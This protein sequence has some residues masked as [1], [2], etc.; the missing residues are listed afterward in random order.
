MTSDRRHSK[1]P[2]KAVRDVNMPESVWRL[3]DWRSRDVLLT[4]GELDRVRAPT[5]DILTLL[6]IRHRADPLPPAGAR[7][8]RSSRAFATRS[9]RGK[10]A[11]TGTISFKARLVPRPPPA[12]AVSSRR[13]LDNFDHGFGNILP[14]GARI[15]TFQS[16][17][18]DEVDNLIDAIRSY[19]LK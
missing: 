11:P 4:D 19:S 1:L 7:G 13:S 5:A 15:V 12:S 2:E 6:P 14:S 10:P 17:S 16:D 3:R 8:P 9:T 18:V